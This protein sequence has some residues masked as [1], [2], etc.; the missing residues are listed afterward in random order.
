MINKKAIIEEIISEKQI[1]ELSA[2][3]IGGKAHYRWNKKEYIKAALL[4]EIADEKANQEYL[5]GLAKLNQRMNHFSRAAF[6]F[7]EAGEFEIALPM[8]IKVCNYDWIKNGLEDD[9]HMI[10]WA[11]T[12]R[13]IYIRDQP[14]KFK[15]LFK[16][17]QK[18]GKEINME[19][20]MIYPKQEL[21]LECAIKM[22]DLELISHLVKMIKKRRPISRVLRAKLKDIEKS[23]NLQTN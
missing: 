11:F 18:R 23:Y 7:Y 6:N 17:A 2:S 9:M 4:F 22:N 19:F 5:T 15:A 16:E 1:N 20:P 10:E 8:L 13:L 12:Y 3:N 21:L 14:E